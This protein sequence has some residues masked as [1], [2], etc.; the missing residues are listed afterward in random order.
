MT[1][2]DFIKNK[3]DLLNKSFPNLSIRYQFDLNAN[4]HLI[5]VMPVLDYENNT[6]YQNAEAELTFEFEQLFSPETVL[7]ISE[8]SLTK[9][10]KPE[11]ESNASITFECLIDQ[12]ISPIEELS[13]DIIYKGKQ[14][15]EFA[16]N[17][18]NYA[19]AA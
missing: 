16:G 15:K 12:L 8:N 19:L 3:I 9:I 11:Y 17:D 5:E 2:N 1:S 13:Q 6:E 4:M 10:T 18:Y 7:F 14:K